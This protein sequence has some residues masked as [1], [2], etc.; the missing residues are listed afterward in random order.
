M[1]GF[2]LSWLLLCGAIS[3]IL[4][5]SGCLAPSHADRCSGVGSA[6]MDDCLRETAVYYQEPETCYGITDMTAREACLRDAVNPD[7]AQRLIEAKQAVGRSVLTPTTPPVTSNVITPPKPAPAPA[8]PSP[9][10]AEALVADCMASNKMSQDACT[11]A[12]AIS[13]QDLLLCESIT[14][15]DIHTHCVFAIASATKDPAS[16]TVLSGDD[17]QLCSYYAKGG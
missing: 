12:V 1:R 6:N 15:P 13:K 2:P 14:A 5:S 17:R 7:A 3:L 8:P 16:C 10:S 4:L 11:Q 9:G